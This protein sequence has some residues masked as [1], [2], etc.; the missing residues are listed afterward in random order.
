MT[1]DEA[2]ARIKAAEDGL[3]PVYRHAK[4]QPGGTDDPQLHAQLWTVEVVDRLDTALQDL[5][6]VREILEDA[7]GEGGA[8]E[9]GT[10]TV[11]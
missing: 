3:T 6:E 8:L 7:D 10:R 1:R 9:P 2:L 4:L 11:G 5:L